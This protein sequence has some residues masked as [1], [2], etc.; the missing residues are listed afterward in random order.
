MG[1]KRTLLRTKEEKERVAYKIPAITTEDLFCLAN[2]NIKERGRGRGKQGK[3]IK[4][5]LRTRILCPKCN[6]PMSVM[7]KEAGSDEVFYYCRAHYCPWITNPCNYRKFIPATW[8]D[9]V[10]E[11]IC[12]L[13]HDDTWLQAQLGEEQNR[14]QDKDKLIQVEDSKMKQARQ[15]LLSI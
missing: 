1:M 4:A 2:Q 5:L 14:V 11:E 13:L 12:H 7:R 8:D 3:S 9:S 10:W 15:R 6:K